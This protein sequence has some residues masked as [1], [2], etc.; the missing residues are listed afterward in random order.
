MKQIAIF[1]TMMMFALATLAQSNADKICGT[2]LVIEKNEVSTVKVSR[3]AN[4]NFEGKIVWMKNPNFDDGSPKTDVKNPDPSKRN[5]PADK[6]VLLH[7]FKYDSK[8]DEWGGEIYNP[9]EGDM[10]KAYAKFESPKKLKVRGYV[11]LP[12]FGRSMYWTKL[13]E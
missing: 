4:G 5:T 6:I 9:V 2:Y 12:I 10:Y 11:G 8:N 7:N 3:M 1:F 13:D